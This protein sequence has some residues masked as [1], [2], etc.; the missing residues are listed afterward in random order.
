MEKALTVNRL[1]KSYGH[2]LAVD[3]LSFEVK[4]G[5]IIGLLGPNGAGKTTSI[6]CILGTRARDGGEVTILGMDPCRDRRRLFARVGVQFQEAQYPDKMRV[7]ELCDVTRSLYRGAPAYDGLLEQFGLADKRKSPVGTLSGGQKQRL[8]VVLALIPG[9]E[10][11]F[12]DELTTGLDPRAR[13]DVWQCLTGLK[14]KGLTVLLT[15]HYMD[16][17]E[18]LCDRI[19]IL[20]QGRA[21]FSGTVQEA[22]AGS[23]H[24]TLEEA[25]LWYTDEE[26]VGY[27]AI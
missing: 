4:K 3:Q 27:E 1:R 10:M 2:I 5:E 14:Q 21:V 15:S 19:E 12:L 20:R 23:P 13:R 18:T 25:Y 17:V 22:V 11:V 6:E 24:G 7:E 16:E 26:E 9:P 8:C